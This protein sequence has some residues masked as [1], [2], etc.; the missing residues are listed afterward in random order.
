MHEELTPYIKQ[1]SAFMATPNIQICVSS[2]GDRMVFGAVSAY[3]EH[4]VF[5]NFFRGLTRRG[6]T[7]EIA[8]NDYDQK[9]SSSLRSSE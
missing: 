7:V 8:S 5:T 1:F 9:D 4:N 3:S 6:L 2:F